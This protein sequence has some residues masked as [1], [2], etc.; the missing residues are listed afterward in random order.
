MEIAPG[1]AVGIVVNP[2]AGRDVRRLTALADVST[3]RGK[4]QDVARA[5]RALFACGVETVWLMPDGGG[6]ARAAVELAAAGR[7]GAGSWS[8]ERVRFTPTPRGDDVGDTLAAVAWMVGR[9]ACAIAWG[10]DGTAR[11]CALAAPTLPL[12]PVAVGTNNVFP[13]RVDG[14]LAGM[15]AAA[16]AVG[17]AGPDDACLRAKRLEVRLHDGTRET[18]LVDA[19]LVE[20]LDVGATAILEPESVRA[21]AL[22]RGEPWDVGLASIGGWLD[23]CAATD[24]WGLLITLAGQSRGGGT[25]AEEVRIPFSPGRL[26]TLAVSARRRLAPDEPVRLSVDGRHGA[27]LACDGERV[28]RLRPGECLEVTLRRDGPLVIDALAALRAA[29]RRGWGRCGRRP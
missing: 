28:R 27:V 19:A 11:A 12:L 2:S 8:P 10:G 20:T 26:V 24:P 4:A 3:A 14:T 5:L 29:G 7:G 13:Q 22:A 15:A 9:V 18:A 16:F 23:P 6:V 21:V 25:H 1:T 17:A